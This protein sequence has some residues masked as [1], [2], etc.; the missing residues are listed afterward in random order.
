VNLL[1]LC[2]DRYCADMRNILHCSFLAR[3]VY[4]LNKAKKPEFSFGIAENEEQGLGGS[5]AGTCFA[6]LS[7]FPHFFA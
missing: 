7:A 4:T 5:L 6:L 3:S 2:P 1:A